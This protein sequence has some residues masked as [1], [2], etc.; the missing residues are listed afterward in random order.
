MFS[1]SLFTVRENV[2]EEA[3]YRGRADQ[4]SI[5]GP[6]E[7]KKQLS[8]SFPNDAAPNISS[9]LTFPLQGQGVVSVYQKHS[10]QNKALLL[11]L[12]SLLSPAF[13][14]NLF[15]PRFGGFSEIL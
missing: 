1:L 2:E 4:I 11:R 3:L 8:R 15:S 12:L 9:F 5:L 10:E 14:S 13:S 6:K 7:E